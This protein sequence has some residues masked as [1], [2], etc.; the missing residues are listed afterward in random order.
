MTGAAGLDRAELAARLALLAGPSAVRRRAAELVLDGGSALE[1]LKRVR[2]TCGDDAADALHSEPV[3]ERVRRSL[4]A[5]A[6]EGIEVIAF[7]DPRLPE[8]ACHRLAND[9]P[10]LLFALGDTALL[11]ATSV[12]IVGSRRATE[13]GLDMA[14]EIGA[15]VAEAGGCVVSGVALGIDAAAQRAALDAGGATIGVLGC[16]VDVLYPRENAALQA[17]IAEEGLLLSE[18]LPGEPPL[19]HNFPRRNRIISALSS[20]VVLVEAGAKSGAISTADHAV[21][22]SVDVFCVPNLYHEP[23]FAGC[24][25][26]L[27]DGGRPFVGVH[28]VLLQAGLARLGGAE[29]DDRA[30]KDEMPPPADPL[31]ASLWETLAAGPRQADRL[32]GLVGA[33]PKETLV[34]LLELE[35]D[36]RVEQRAGQQYS[37]V[38]P[39]RR[40]AARDRR[41][42]VSEAGT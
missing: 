24:L 35:L 41:S 10:I 6:R 13:Y 21:R 12:A 34:A 8:L 17:R 37:R 20:A 39:R 29:V 4:A 15:A 27:R 30:P 28:D 16:G 33:G 19:R 36:G 2:D 3:R 31:Q 5:I 26:L 42:N 7:E 23:N 38:K 40:R 11:S 9:R 18:Q 1:A 14:E 25:A 32:A 22:Q